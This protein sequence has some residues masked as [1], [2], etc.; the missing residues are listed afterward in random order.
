MNRRNF[1]RSLATVCGAAVACPGELVKGGPEWMKYARCFRS[2]NKIMLE[3]F[4]AAALN[5]KYKN[6]HPVFRGV[7]IVYRSPLYDETNQIQDI[8]TTHRP[9][10]IRSQ[11][12]DSSG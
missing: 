5:T 1:L 6:G 10:Q 2:E 9:N 12:C 8:Q 3:K 7:P 11:A 4:R